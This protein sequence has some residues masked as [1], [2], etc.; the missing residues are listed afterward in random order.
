MWVTLYLV[1]FAALADTPQ[2]RIDQRRETVLSS[3][4]ASDFTSLFENDQLNKEMRTNRA[5]RL[6]SFT[7]PPITFAPT[8]KY[9]PHTNDYDSSEKKRIPAWCDRVLFTSGP[10][11]RST[12]YRRYEPTVSDHRPVSAGLAI[13]LKRVD[14]DKMREV[15][16]KVGEEWG[17]RE[18]EML[19]KMAEVF[20]DLW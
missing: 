20:A 1:D 14:K 11:I 10:R 3:I 17:K 8:Y 2:Y 6:R 7:E 19:G 9:N 12:S 4:L 5:F 13:T 18:M 16:R 15:R